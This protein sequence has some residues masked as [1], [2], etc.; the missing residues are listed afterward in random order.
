MNYIFL[1]TGQKGNGKGETAKIIRKNIENTAIFH[2]SKPIK[3]MLATLLNMTITDLEKKKNDTIMF[4]GLTISIR[5]ALQ[6]LGTEWGRDQI[7]KKI[8]VKYLCKS[9]SNSHIL[10]A[11]VEDVRFNNEVKEIKKEFEGKKKVV[12]IKIDMGKEN[13]DKHISENEK[14]NYDYLIRNVGDLNLLEKNIITIIN[15]LKYL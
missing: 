14:I 7:D 4:C 13:K 12:V 5:K 11:V 10:N 15:K 8:W 9:I 3:L 2:L 1:L 6:S